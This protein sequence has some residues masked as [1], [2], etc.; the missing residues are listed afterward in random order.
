MK[1]LSMYML[2]DTLYSDAQISAIGAFLCGKA[3]GKTPYNFLN[4]SES[5]FKVPFYFRRLIIHADILRR[6]KSI[7]CL[8][9]LCGLPKLMM[10]VNQG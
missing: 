6:L 9:F 1:F 3:A 5:D 8:R 2:R 7:L 4:P 10:K